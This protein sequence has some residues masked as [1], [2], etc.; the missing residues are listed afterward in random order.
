MRNSFYPKMAVTNIR[1]N[2]GM[3]VP[4]MLTCI[5]TIIMYLVMSAISGNPGIDEMRGSE[6]LRMVLQF[7]QSIIAIFSVIFLFYTNSFLMKRRKK[8]LGLYS[9]LGLEKRHIG[10]IL[11]YECI[12]TS[13]VSLGI[14]LL[15]GILISK[16]MFLIL[17]KLIQT[18][19]DFEFIMSRDAICSTLIL[20]GIIFACTLLSNLFM[21]GKSKPI[22]LL[23]GGNKGEKEPKARWI[24]ALIGLICTAVGY[25][26][27]ITVK[28]P[29]DALIQFFIA[30]L[31]VI[32]GTYLLFITGSIAL[33][34]ILKKNKAFYYRQKHFTSVSGMIYRMKQNAVGLANIC[35]LSTGVLLSIATTISL[36]IGI[37][38]LIHNMYP[39]QYS[40][41]SYHA[42]EEEVEQMKNIVYQEAEKNN[43]KVKDY[44][45]YRYNSLGVSQIDNELQLVGVDQG[46]LSACMLMTVD[47][48]NEV[49]GTDKKLAEDEVLIID[50]KKSFAY[51]TLRI[52]SSEYKVSEEIKD[53]DM[54][55]NL[56]INMLDGYGVVFANQ[57]IINN[58][59]I[60][61]GTDINSGSEEPDTFIGFNADGDQ[62]TLDHFTNVLHKKLRT[63]LEASEDL[64]INL[65]DR[66][67]GAAMLRASI[68]SFLFI[69]VFIG[70]L[71][72]MA[73]V[74]II[75]YKQISEGY[76]DKERFSIMQKVGMS[77]GEVKKSIRSQ[78]LTVFFLP[79]VV[80]ILHV[81]AAFNMMSKLL[82][83]FGLFNTDLFVICTIGTIIIFAIIYS[84]VFTMTAKTY[85]KIVG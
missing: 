40:M 18:N 39:E 13:A 55:A 47:N 23:Y 22:E 28:S 38:E 5:C 4:Y 63:M 61:A 71:F 42:T 83:M 33:L 81:A 1:K 54:I 75:Y 17:L 76:E 64:F 45:Q 49:M 32:V 56:T 36:N 21:T 8:E 2:A 29:I 80:A 26:M 48:Y 67:S 30:V 50:F 74:L 3:Y 16:L 82:F 68:S 69:G 35:I 73:T 72:L 51:P 9:I 66:D 20:F 57:E 7:G 84:F 34:K 46:N 31:L 78:I 43:I 85:Y 44:S 59:C 11:L 12:F 14:G 79:L 15:G 6:S 10:R 62:K 19:V 27:A 41:T 24:T 52:G 65:S 70:V 60:A 37:E 25:F 53:N 77:K 58:I